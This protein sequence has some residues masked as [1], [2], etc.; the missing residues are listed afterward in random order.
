MATRQSTIDALLDQLAGAG[1][2]TARKM[3]GEYCVYLDATPVGF[4]CRDF[5]YVKPSTVGREFARDATEAAP[6][7][8]IRPYLLISMDQADQ[9]AYREMLCQLLRLTA[10]AQPAPKTRTRRTLA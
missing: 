2:V 1:H 8:G 5:L 7:P 10:E 4:V 9:W 6:F 3:F